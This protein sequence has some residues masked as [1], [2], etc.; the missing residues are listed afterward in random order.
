MMADSWIPIMLPTLVDVPQEPVMIPL[1][2]LENQ[3]PT[4]E[5]K[6]GKQIDCAAPIITKHI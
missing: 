1:D 3:P 5:T 6:H 2:D 4:I